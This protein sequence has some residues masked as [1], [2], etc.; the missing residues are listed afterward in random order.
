MKRK[1]LV[2]G[3]L[4]MSSVALGVWLDPTRV[5]WGWLRGEAF[6]QGRPTSYWRA[7]LMHWEGPIWIDVPSPLERWHGPQQKELWKRHPGFWATLFPALFG[8]ADQQKPSIMYGPKAAK[9]VLAELERDANPQ[10]R[11]LASYGLRRVRDGKGD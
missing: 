11:K 5:V 7:E 2:I 10:I 3:L 6:Y 8:G 4:L 1:L 9:E